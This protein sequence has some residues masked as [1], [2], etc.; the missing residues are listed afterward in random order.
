MSEQGRKTQTPVKGHEG[1][2][3]GTNEKGQ[4]RARLKNGLQMRLKSMERSES[5]LEDL[6]KQ[7][8]RRA[9]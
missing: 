5:T 1:G 7:D 6:A 2:N 3:L 8:W 9:E 4:A